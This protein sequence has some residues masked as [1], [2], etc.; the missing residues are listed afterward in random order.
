MGSSYTENATARTTLSY[1]KGID[2]NKLME[3]LVQEF[4]SSRP[5]EDAVTVREFMENLKDIS[6]TNARLFL[7]RK[8]KNEGWTRAKY[9]GINYYWKPA[10]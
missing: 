9:L 1:M 7:D 3:E 10:D 2:M 4:N 6:M 8:V 5:P